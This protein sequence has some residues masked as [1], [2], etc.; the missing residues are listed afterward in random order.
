MAE[1]SSD[2]PFTIAGPPKVTFPNEETYMI[3][4]QNYQ[5]K[6]TNFRGTTVKIELLDFGV[7]VEVLSPGT[8]NDGMFVWQAQKP[9]IIL[10]SYRIRITSVQYPSFTDTSDEHFEI[11]S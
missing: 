9:K 7:P 8:A 6:W 3:E 5:I 1:D 11:G 4:G 10:N 2:N